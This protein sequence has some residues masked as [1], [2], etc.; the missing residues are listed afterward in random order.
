MIVL[1]ESNVLKY[2]RLALQEETWKGERSKT[3]E[4]SGLLSGAF[5]LFSVG[6]EGPEGNLIR[7]RVDIQ[8]AT[9]QSYFS[10]SS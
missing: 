10:L 2:S 7:R 4:K 5:I 3:A 6:G 8:T 9:V 1:P